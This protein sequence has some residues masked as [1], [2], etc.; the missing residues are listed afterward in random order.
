MPRR[1]VANLFGQGV[2]DGEITVGGGVLVTHGRV[3]GGVT[4]A[5][6]QVGERC[7]A[8]G[9]QDGARVPEGVEREIWA[10]SGVAG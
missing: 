4:E 1:K 6:H 10:S 3:G 8:L 7:A 9:G 2:G 5:G